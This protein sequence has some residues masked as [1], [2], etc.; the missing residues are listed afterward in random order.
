MVRKSTTVPKR[1][2]RPRTKAEAAIVPEE[3]TKSRR[4]RSGEKKRRAEAS[5]MQRLSHLKLQVNKTQFRRVVMEAMQDIAPDLRISSRSIPLIGELVQAKM[6]R[7][8][9]AAR[10]ICEAAGKRKSVNL[11]ALNTA[12][13]LV[14]RPELSRSCPALNPDSFDSSTTGITQKIIVAP[15]ASKAAPKKKAPAKKKAEAAEEEK[16]EAAEEPAVPK[17]EEEK[18]QAETAGGEAESSDGEEEEES[19]DEE[20][21][22]E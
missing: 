12:V 3:A 5:K 8:L 21:G 10:L 2:G 11:R 15:S 4:R 19:S 16:E 14:L 17:P 9:V 1:G 7:A 6:H 13:A 18:P 20:E 22:D